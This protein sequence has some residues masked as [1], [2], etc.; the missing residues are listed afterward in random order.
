[1][2]PDRGYFTASH[3]SSYPTPIRNSVSH[4]GTS[5]TSGSAPSDS[6]ADDKR[7]RREEEHRRDVDAARQA[8]VESTEIWNPNSDE[9]VRSG[10]SGSTSRHAVQVPL[11]SSSS[12]THRQ[13]KLE[14]FVL[15]T[16]SSQI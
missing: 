13:I 14:R 9:A 12:F 11:F 7:P 10:Y 1:L 3:P 4:S 15:Q 16:F 8:A 6:D 5:R 2:T